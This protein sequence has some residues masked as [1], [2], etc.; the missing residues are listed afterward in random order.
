MVDKNGY[1]VR[2][3]LRFETG[4]WRAEAGPK[5]TKDRASTARIARPIHPLSLFVDKSVPTRPLLNSWMS[6]ACDLP[7]WPWGPAFHIT[8]SAWL[9]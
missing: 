1:N 5:Y 4:Y 8:F 9:R 6:G 7:S 2:Q 3:D